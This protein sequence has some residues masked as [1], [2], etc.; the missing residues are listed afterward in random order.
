[1]FKINGRVVNPEM[2]GKKAS[3]WVYHIDRWTWSEYSDTTIMDKPYIFTYYIL[4]TN[5]TKI[6]KVDLTNGTF[7]DCQIHFVESK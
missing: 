1:M 4:F 5:H 2:G 3:Y 6:G 7:F